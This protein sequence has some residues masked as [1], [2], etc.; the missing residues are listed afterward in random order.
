MG[1]EEYSTCTHVAAQHINVC[2]F[3]KQFTCIYNRTLSLSLSFSTAKYEFLIN[4]EGEREVNTFLSEDHSL[5]EYKTVSKPL[6]HIIQ[7]YNTC[8][9]AS[10]SITFMYCT[11]I[12]FLGDR[13]VQ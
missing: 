1:D 8:N 11:F 12:C 6:H 5:E 2:F 10:L 13:E 4:G 3:F 7:M 9:G